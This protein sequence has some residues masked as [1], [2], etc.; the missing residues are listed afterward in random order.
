[1]ASLAT[2]PGPQSFPQSIAWELD[3]GGIPMNDPDKYSCAFGFNCLERSRSR[4]ILAYPDFM[5]QWHDGVAVDCS[6]CVF[7]VA[8]REGRRDF[9]SKRSDDESDDE[10]EH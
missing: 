1:V 2:F 5:R 8:E 7:H 4:R 6:D 9:L 10:N 3:S